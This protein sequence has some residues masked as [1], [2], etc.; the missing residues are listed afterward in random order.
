MKSALHVFVFLLA[1]SCI[2]L[3]MCVWVPVR[4]VAGFL[5]VLDAMIIHAVRWLDSAAGRLAN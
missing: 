5:I 1:L 3:L 4:I 2:A